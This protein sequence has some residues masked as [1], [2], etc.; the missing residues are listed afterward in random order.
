[1]DQIKNYIILI[2]GLFFSFSGFAQNYPEVI[3]PHSLKTI[4]SGAD[5][6]WVLKDSQLKKAILS[7]KKL[8]VEEE[9]TSDLKQKINVL[10]E[11][12]KVKDSLIVD[13]KKDR[14]Y[15]VNNWKICTDDI[16]LLLKKNKRQKMLTR[17][18]FLGIIVAFVGGFLIGN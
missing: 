5:T 18:S 4:E 3:L 1:M 9:I 12:N 2:L 11:N 6:L 17:L 13:L 8:V 10:E 14:D 16:D 7:A 15:Y